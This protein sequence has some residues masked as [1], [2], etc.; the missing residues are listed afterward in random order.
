MIIGWN[1]FW[2]REVSTYWWW[3]SDWILAFALVAWSGD[4]NKEC[5]QR[6][7]PKPKKK[8]QKAVCNKID[9]HSHTVDGRNPAP[10]DGSLSHYLQ[11]FIH[12]RWWSPDFFHQQYVIFH[13][14]DLIEFPYVDFWHSRFKRPM[15]VQ[16]TW[17]HQEFAGL[18]S[19]SSQV[20]KLNLHSSFIPVG[21]CWDIPPLMLEFF[22]CYF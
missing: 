17:F 19:L 6:V 10:V 7:S 3:I 1:E 9:R 18:K 15:M 4:F 5:D 20:R 22:S 16:V 2:I 11:E 14:L 21:Q 8:V 12:P 13:Y